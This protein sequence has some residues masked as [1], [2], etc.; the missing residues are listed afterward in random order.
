MTNRYRY[1]PDTKKDQEK[2]KQ[3]IGIS[4][5]DELFEVI[6]SSVRQTKQMAIEGG[7]SEIELTRHLKKLARQNLSAEEAVYFLGAGTYDHFIPSVVDHVVSRSEFTTAYTPYQPEASQGELQA[8]FEF[9]TMI[10]ELTGM[11][12]SNSSLYDGFA[13]L[14]EACNLAVSVQKRSKILYSSAI[15]PQAAEVIQTY[16][17]GMEY[18]VMPVEQTGGTTNLNHLKEVLDKETAAVIIQY[19]NFFG[20]VEDLQR[21]KEL[22]NETGALMIV[23]A[24]PLALGI[25][26]SPGKLGADIV[27]GDMQ[28]LGIPMAY[29]GPHCGYFTVLK[30]YMRKVPSRIVGE[31]KDADGKRGYVMTLQTREQHIRREKATSNMSSNQAL[32]AL[33][34]AVCMS[35]LGKQGIREMAMQ[36]YQ[37]THYLADRLREKGWK[38]YNS[39]A[40]FNE[41]ALELNRPIG[42][43]NQQLL[44]EG[45]VGGL[46]ISEQTKGN[47]MLLC[48]TEKRTKNEMDR[49]IE[50]LEEAD[51]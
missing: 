33:S 1:L 7:F 36:N 32:M 44:K 35:A 21:V 38:I 22:C 47:H 14:G 41:F 49:L 46:D 2:M 11:D 24:N 31:T 51:K 50:L 40:F 29:G 45:I 6:P 12:V 15:H 43:I 39:S 16:A 9:Q 23:S 37:K 17:S 20:T 27:V 3:T 42:E 19:P 30:K 10:C 8:L 18:A 5:I 4:S 13:S 34:S 26:E 48:A 25:L 28:P